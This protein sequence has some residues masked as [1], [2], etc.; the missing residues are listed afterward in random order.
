MDLIS[1]GE[2][3]AEIIYARKTK[4]IAEGKIGAKKWT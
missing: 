1:R 3:E 2:L 4:A